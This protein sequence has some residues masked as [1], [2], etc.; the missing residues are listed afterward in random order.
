MAIFVLVHGA[1]GGGWEWREVERLLRERGHEATRPTLTGLGEPEPEPAEPSFRLEGDH[2]LERAE[3][4]D[5]A[6]QDRALRR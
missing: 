2:E 5:R 1:W 6:G 3:G 4:H